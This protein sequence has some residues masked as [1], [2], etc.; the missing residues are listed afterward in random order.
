MYKMPQGIKQTATIVGG[1]LFDPLLGWGG[2]QKS[3]GIEGL[4]HVL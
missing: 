1:G 2:C 4:T 3:L